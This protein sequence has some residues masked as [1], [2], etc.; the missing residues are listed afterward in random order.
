VTLDDLLLLKRRWGVSVAAIVMRLKALNIID[1]DGAQ[2]LFKRRSARWGAKSEP[3]D[4]DRQPEK[5]RL[6]GRTIDLLVQQN[7]MPLDAIPRHLGLSVRDLE[8]L[9]GLPEGY[10]LGKDNVVQ[11]V[12]LRQTA[13]PSSPR[14][15]STTSKILPFRSKT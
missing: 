6:L 9:I 8:M 11:L 1:D 7:V 13:V 4:S 5:P 15:E 14:P 3:N 12:Q 10:F 2:L